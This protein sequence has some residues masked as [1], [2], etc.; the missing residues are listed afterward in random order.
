MGLWGRRAG[1][2]ERFSKCSAKGYKRGCAS[3][4]PEAHRSVWEHGSHRTRT[5][6]SGSSSEH[7]LHLPPRSAAQH[8]PKS[9]APHPLPQS[10]PP[11]SAPAPETSVAHRL[12]SHWAPCQLY[13]LQGRLPPH[14]ESPARTPPAPTPPSLRPRPRP[15]AAR[16]GQHQPLLPYPRHHRPQGSR[17]RKAGCPARVLPSITPARPPRG[18][19]SRTG[20]RCTDVPAPR[21]TTYCKVFPYTEAKR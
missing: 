13:P 20:G 7:R 17:G 19:G 11:S 4:F 8:L 16:Q 15:P 10:P 14:T 6:L 2:A 3:C 21:S 1:G 9:P 12:S 18:R 5:I